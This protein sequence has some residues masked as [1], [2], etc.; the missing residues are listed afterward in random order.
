MNK[1][2]MKAPKVHQFDTKGF[3]F[4][5]KIFVLLLV[6]MV[7]FRYGSDAIA[8]QIAGKK[9]ETLTPAQKAI[10]QEESFLEGSSI[11]GQKIASIVP[12]KGKF[13]GVDLSHMEILL[14]K[15][16]KVVSTYKVLS[17]GEPGSH[18]EVPSGV[19]GV[20]KKEDEH[21]STIGKVDLPYSL[22]FSGNFSIHGWPTYPNGQEV[23]KNFYGGC[24]RLSTEDAEAV[25]MFADVGTGLFVYAPQLSS[26]AVQVPVASVQAPEV[27]AKAYLVEDLD[28]KEIY[29]EKNA[30]ESF[31]IASVTKLMT[32]LVAHDVE[33]F[34]QEE[35]VDGSGVWVPPDVPNKKAEQMSI[36]E[37][38]YPLFLDSNNDVADSLARYYGTDSFL[39]LM[40][41]KALSLGMTDTNYDDPSGLSKHNTSTVNDL[42]KLADYIFHD[43]SFLI[44]ITR[45]PSRSIIS[46]SGKEYVFDNH[47]HFLDRNDYL[48]GKIGFTDEA[49]ETYVAFFKEPIGGQDHNIVI[50]VLKSD[51]RKDDTLSLLNWLLA[52]T[53]A[54]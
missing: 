40:N 33:S 12:E 54:E 6:V 21:F 47:T 51:N 15:D 37:L 41:E 25:Y 23:S 4:F 35:P 46:N 10:A 50:I 26:T 44:N 24:V 48:G 20:E 45:Q 36:G 2:L 49:L 8:G 52:A 43:E 32:A 22:D 5:L 28:S 16:G 34:D 11:G 13:I 14:Y 29:L 31:P 1:N 19:Y 18:W 38:L 7:S 42:F 9:P 27:T 17:K 53:K 39:K 30:N 3:T